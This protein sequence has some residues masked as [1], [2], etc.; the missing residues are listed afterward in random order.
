MSETLRG[1]ATI[2]FFAEDH[3]AAQAW[4]TDVLGIEPYFA[5]PGYVEFRLGDYQQELGLID[6]KYAPNFIQLGLGGAILYWHVDDIQAT[7]ER[8]VSKGA[9]P[10]E[11][12]QHRG[13]GFITAVV[14]DPFG[15]ILGI[16]I[17]PHYLEVLGSAAPTTKEDSA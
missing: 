10:L 6:R 13:G 4:Y 11:A 2:N 7:F 14:A 5:R 16:M 12:P 1:V 17:N 8:L 3:A 9:T 15:N